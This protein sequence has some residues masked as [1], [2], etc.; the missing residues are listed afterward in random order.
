[1]IRAGLLLAL[2]LAPTVAQAGFFDT[3]YCRLWPR[4]AV[5][6]IEVPLPPARPAPP[7]PV[8]QDSPKAVPPAA[9]PSKPAK[10]I[11]ESRTRKA[12]PKPKPAAPTR[13][14][15]AAWCAQVPAWA[16]LDHIKLAA[17]QRGHTMTA[18]QIEQAEACLASKRK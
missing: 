7:R 18:T 6:R 2:T 12:V 16:T 11:P 17:A 5:C 3:A 9:A 14:A 15:A 4:A 10:R 1:M 8:A 13:Q